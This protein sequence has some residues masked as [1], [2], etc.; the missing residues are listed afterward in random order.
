[1]TAQEPG[2]IGGLVPDAEMALGPLSLRRCRNVSVSI[3]VS[4]FPNRAITTHRCTAQGF[5]L[6]PIIPP[7]TL[8]FLF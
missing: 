7:F 1:M 8:L 4:S 5:K 2:R 3:A 6:K